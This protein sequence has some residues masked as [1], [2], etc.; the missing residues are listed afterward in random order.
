MWGSAHNKKNVVEI[1]LSTTFFL[2]YITIN[3]VSF[4]TNT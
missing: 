3:L 4:I 2:F 1:Q